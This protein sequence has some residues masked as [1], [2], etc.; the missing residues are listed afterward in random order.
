MMDSD[1]R[2]WEAERRSHIQGK[3]NSQLF[4][5]KLQLFPRTEEEE[6][7]DHR[8]KRAS[9]STTR[10]MGEEREEEK[11]GKERRRELGKKDFSSKAEKPSNNGEEVH[12]AL[13]QQI[14]TVFFLFLKLKE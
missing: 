14:I 7:K 9:W 8:Q 12:T 4:F 10:W 11:E 3:K 5:F 2:E 1:V 13:F 6:K